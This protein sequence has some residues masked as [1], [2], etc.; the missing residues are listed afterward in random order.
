[1]TTNQS[2]AVSLVRSLLD[3]AVQNGGEC[4]ATICPLC[5]MTLE[6]YQ[7]DINRECATNFKLPLLYFTQLMGLAFGFGR[8]ELGIDQELVSSRAVLETHLRVAR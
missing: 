2:V 3:C 7:G 6:A 5:H 4:I 8:K 1:M